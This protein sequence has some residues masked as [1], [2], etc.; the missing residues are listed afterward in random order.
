LLDRVLIDLASQKRQKWMDILTTKRQTLV[1]KFLDKERTSS[2]EFADQQ[3]SETLVDEML[4]F[5][6]GKVR[7]REGD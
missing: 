1:K 4:E 6:A 5:S 3:L 7:K 2:S